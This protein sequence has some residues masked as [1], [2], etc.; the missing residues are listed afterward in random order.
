MEIFFQSINKI[1]YSIPYFNNSIFQTKI[2]PPFPISFYSIACP[3]Y[4]DNIE[5]TE[6][7]QEI[8]NVFM[9]LHANKEA[10]MNGQSKQHVPA[11]K[12]YTVYFA[13]YFAGKYI[14]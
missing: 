7:D 4:A 14:L 9:P 3:G 1:F 8:K 12:V 5:F 11:G 10:C 6:T 2:F 13:G